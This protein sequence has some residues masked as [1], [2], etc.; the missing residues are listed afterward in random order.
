MT[1]EPANPSPRRHEWRIFPA[2]A[3]I[4]I[5]V[6]FLLGNLGYRLDLLEYGNWWAW[7]ILVA[8]LAPLTRA[9]EVYR[10]RGRIDGDV[11]HY[12]LAAGGVTLVAVMFLAGLDWTV[13]WPLFLILGGLFTLV[14]RPYS[15]R[16]GYR[17]RRC[18]SDDEDD[19]SIKR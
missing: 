4:A 9:Y 11:V 14:R 10:A 13:W 5:G 17:S 12:L 6:L 16:Y 7:F 2:V 18:G 15:R 8:A 19:A 1:T 3:I